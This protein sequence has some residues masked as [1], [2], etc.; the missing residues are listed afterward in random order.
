MHRVGCCQ[1]RYT[2]AV[3]YCT[4]WDVAKD[5]GYTRAV[6]YCTEW[7]VAKDIGY[8]RAVDYCT[9][10]DVAK[11]IGYT[12]AVDYCTEWD[13]AKD[14][15]YTRVSGVVPGT[16]INYTVSNT[17]LLPRQH[18]HEHHAVSHLQHPHIGFC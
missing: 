2:R 12:R 11:D 1:G 4:E 10:W 18:N 6:D 13:V 5:I 8:T 16:C 15:G 3:D 7:D 17:A 14:I 9:E